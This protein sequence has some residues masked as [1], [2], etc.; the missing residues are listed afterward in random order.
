MKKTDEN[1]QFPFESDAFKNW[2]NIWLK[3]KKEEHKQSYKSSITIQAALKRL[4]EISNGNETT[5]I[6]IIEQSIANCWKGLFE[7]KQQTNGTSKH[8]KQEQFAEYFKNKSR[9]SGNAS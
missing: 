4:S 6:K 9:E 7:L 5:A 1:I 3:Y 2:W 8:G